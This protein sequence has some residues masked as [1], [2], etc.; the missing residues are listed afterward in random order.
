MTKLAM[1]LRAIQSSIIGMTFLSSNAEA[2]TLLDNATCTL[3]AQCAFGF[4]Y[5][6]Q[7]GT[8]GLVN[9]D[10]GYH[11]DIVSSYV[12]KTGSYCFQPLRLSGAF[13]P[14]TDSAYCAPVLPWGG[15]CSTYIGDVSCNNTAACIHQNTKNSLGLCGVPTPSITTGVGGVGASCALSGQCM[16]GFCNYPQ[17]QQKTGDNCT[18]TTP[19]PDPLCYSGTCG[20]DLKC[21]PIS[22]LNAPLTF[23]PHCS[24]DADCSF[25]FCDKNHLCVL[26]NDSRIA[27]QTPLFS[28]SYSTI[29]GSSGAVAS[30]TGTASGSSST[31][32]SHSGAEMLAL[33]WKELLGAGALA[34]G[35]VALL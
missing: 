20:S 25:G 9:L 21:A 11:C 28:G 31:G 29:Y 14:P 16:F 34:L 12:C 1:L 24:A 3:D 26:R 17:C 4:C 7:C 13:Q 6:G 27:L 30:A 15:V 5:G 18:V 8:A 35:A 19:G 22:P 33:G 32:S 2:A 23:L 10:D